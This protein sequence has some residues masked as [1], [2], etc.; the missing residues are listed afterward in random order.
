MYRKPPVNMW[1][2][3]YEKDIIDAYGIRFSADIMSGEDGEFM[4]KYVSHCKS[5]KL[6]NLPLNGY[7]VNLDSASYLR[8]DRIVESV[9]AVER[10]IDHDR[11]YAPQMAVR[12]ENYLLPR[13]KMSVATKFCRQRRY[14]AFVKFIRDCWS[15][16]DYR[17]ININA[18][19][20]VVKVGATLLYRF[21]ALYYGLLNLLF[22]F[23]PQ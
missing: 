14:N 4:L 9:T 20:V 1:C 11:C 19:Q 15:E 21:P 13:V 3:L 7:R 8:T 10:V 22:V 23:R 12:I 2:F 16:E 5:G 17:K 6:I 18:N